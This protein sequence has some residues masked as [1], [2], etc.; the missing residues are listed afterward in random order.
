MRAVLT[1]IGST[2]DIQPFLA[3]AHQ[4][5]CQGHD[6]I[7][8]LPPNF[9]PRVEQLGYQFVK[10]GPAL[11]PAAMRGVVTTMLTMPDLR[12]QVK[13]FFDV[14]KPAIPQLF[15]ELK[16]ICRDADVL[17]STPHQ[18]AGRMAHDA[19]GIPFVSIHLSPFGVTGN[20]AIND[21]SAPVINESRVAE[22]LAPLKDPLGADGVS[23]QLALYAVSRHIMRLPPKAPDS[24]HVTGFFYH[25][26][27]EWEPDEDLL[28]FVKAGDALIAITF[29]SVVHQDP[30]ALTELLVAA[31][32]RAGC[33]AVIQRG[34]SG[35]AN[36]ELPDKI[37]AIDYVPHRWLFANVKCV[38]HHGGAGTTA[39]AFRAGVP[40]VVVTHNLDQPMWGEL[41]R[42]LGCAG[43]VIP[44]QKLTAQNLGDAIT[45][46]LHSPQRFVA[47]K[48][49]ADKIK[50]EHGV[51]AACR[52]IGRFNS[53][54]TRSL[55]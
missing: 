50:D 22:K 37:K 15:R 55:E 28:E 24:L 9:K 21:A 32:A 20:K 30:A 25:D 2:G 11:N 39:A 38:V 49:F 4:L 35:L 31:I 19:T 44:F 53:S 47:A 45:G 41:A 27:D 12:D 51:E 3:L 17:L 14:V 40:T 23:T 1:S 13:H 33:R 5:R 16:E 8:A 7:L 42:A 36:V 46:V 29:G 54:M 26:E 18:F 10:I 52:L 6:P 48:Q 34:W 43:A